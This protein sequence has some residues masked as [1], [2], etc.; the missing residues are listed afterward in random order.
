MATRLWSFSHS[1]TQVPQ[2]IRYI[3]KQEEHH[4]R[5]TFQE[6]YLDILEKF[7]V[8]FDKRYVFKPLE[9]R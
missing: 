5:I 8:D 2:V 4:K 1:K 9:D 7:K 3:E 6:E